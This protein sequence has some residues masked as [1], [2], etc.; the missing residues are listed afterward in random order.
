AAVLSWRV[1]LLVVPRSQGLPPVSAVTAGSR[2][3][4]ASH[5]DVHL[6]ATSDRPRDCREQ[7]LRGL[8][9]SIRKSLR[10]CYVLCDTS[11][12]GS[13]ATSALSATSGRSTSSNEPLSACS[14]SIQAYARTVSV[15][16]PGSAL[17]TYPT[18]ESATHTG[19]EPCGRCV[20]PYS[21]RHTNRRVAGAAK[22][23]MSPSRPRKYPLSIRT[24]DAIPASNGSCSAVT[25]MP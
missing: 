15:V 21:S 8:S 14:V 20:A 10:I 5:D 13:G 4:S 25:S 17:V 12:T 1:R 24:A 9:S 16:Y 18:V 2:A 6:L 19:S 3:S 11:R 7:F 22:R 23:S